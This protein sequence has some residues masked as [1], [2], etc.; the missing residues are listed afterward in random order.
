MAHKNG[1]FNRLDYQDQTLFGIDSAT[2]KII[3]IVIPHRMSKDCEY[4]KTD[5]YNDQGCVGCTRKTTQ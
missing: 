3:K 4:Q 1:C 5:K 2:G